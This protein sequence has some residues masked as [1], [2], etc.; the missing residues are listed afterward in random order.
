MKVKIN[1]MSVKFKRWGKFD[2][3]IWAFNAKFFDIVREQTVF[4]FG[5]LNE[6]CSL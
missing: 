1:A 4:R 5:V 3:K 6:L 2:A